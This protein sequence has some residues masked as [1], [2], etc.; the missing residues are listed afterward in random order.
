VV[1]AA[2]ADANGPDSLPL[3]HIF[4]RL[5]E[6]SLHVNFKFN[7][8]IRIKVQKLSECQAGLV[9]NWQGARLRI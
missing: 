5:H 2:S 4:L 3:S 9:N 8:A 1:T 7:S 6:W